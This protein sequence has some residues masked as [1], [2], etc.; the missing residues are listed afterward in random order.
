MRHR[1]PK[2]HSKTPLRAHLSPPPPFQVTDNQLLRPNPRYAI[3]PLP[4]NGSAGGEHPSG[5]TGLGSPFKSFSV[6]TR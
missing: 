2:S 1:F 4:T 3:Y 5:K 6:A